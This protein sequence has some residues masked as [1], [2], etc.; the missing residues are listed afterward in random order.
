MYIWNYKDADILRQDST[1][2]IK[3]QPQKLQMKP[4]KPKIGN[5]QLLEAGL[6][7]RWGKMWPAIE[8]S[9]SILYDLGKR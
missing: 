6:T 2:Y 7:L 1:F 4:Y 5:F 3:G 9:I 8:W